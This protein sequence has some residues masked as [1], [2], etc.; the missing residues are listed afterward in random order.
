M[1]ENR[2]TLTQLVEQLQQRANYQHERN[3][4][5]VA[6]PLET[7]H[8]DARS[9]AQMIGADY[10]DFDC[11]LLAEFEADDWDDHVQ[12]ERKNTLSIAQMV[13]RDWLTKVAQRINR[14]RP[15][16][17]GNINL[18]VRYSIDV[19]Q[20]LYD[21]TVQG[22]CIIAAGGRVQGQTLLIHGVLTQTGAS[23]PAY[24]VVQ[25]PDDTS[26]RHTQT[27]QERLL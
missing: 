12:M 11:E 20:A 5:L 26:P 15:L 21:A 9:L 8:R 17:V 16:V 2:L 1:S 4:I 18:A 19:A 13:I 22:L 10:L 23:S 6:F 14:K 3:L 7:A 27:I 25:P 24:E